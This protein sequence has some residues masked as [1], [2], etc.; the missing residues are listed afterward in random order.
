M[1]AESFNSPMVRWHYCS[2]RQQ[3][4]SFLLTIGAKALV[5]TEAVDLQPAS[6]KLAG[7]NE[8]AQ[9]RKVIVSQERVRSLRRNIVEKVPLRVCKQARNGEIRPI[10]VVVKSEGHQTEVQSRHLFYLLLPPP[11]NLAREDVEAEDCL[12]RLFLAHLL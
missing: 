2:A 5:M 7:I 9:M 10:E 8:E 4:L 6:N 3:A 12:P 11:L 1:F